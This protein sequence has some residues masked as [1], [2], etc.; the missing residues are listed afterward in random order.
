LRQIVGFQIDAG[1]MAIFQPDG[2]GGAK[3][4]GRLKVEDWFDD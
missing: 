1:E 3:L 2:H 4:I